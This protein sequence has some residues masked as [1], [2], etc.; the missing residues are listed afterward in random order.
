[1]GRR[2]VLFLSVCTFLLSCS[3]QNTT[4]LS[5]SE[6]VPITGSYSEEGLSGTVLLYDS[7]ALILTLDGAIQRSLLA[8]RGL[9][10]AE[11]Q[12]DS[13]RLSLVAAKSQ[14]ELKFRPSAN[15]G[16]G[17]HSTSGSNKEYGTGL[18]I[19]KRFETG[20]SVSVTPRL[21]RVSGSY[22]SGVDVS[23]SQPLLLG[24]DRE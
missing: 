10:A 9:I 19:D 3:N 11:D 24:T 22:Q 12:V 14:F 18:T 17:K 5:P 20:T 4:A 6:Y 13:T 15:V 2:I 8:N 16:F 7:K 23:L 1:M 21:D